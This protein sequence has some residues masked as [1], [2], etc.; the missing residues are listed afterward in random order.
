MVAEKLLVQQKKSACSGNSN[1]LV[2][3][4]HCESLFLSR[5]TARVLVD[6]NGDNGNCN[7]EASEGQKV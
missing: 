2:V 4:Y 7:C 1:I 6:E 3:G 5:L